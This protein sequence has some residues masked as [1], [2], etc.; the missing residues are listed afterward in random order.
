MYLLYNCDT[1]ILY[2][3]KGI[4]FWEIKRKKTNLCCLLKKVKTFVVFKLLK[5]I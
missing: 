1:L 4:A 2:L 3:R 5:N